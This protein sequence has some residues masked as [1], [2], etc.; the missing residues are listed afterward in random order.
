MEDNV[1]DVILA[2]IVTSDQ[3]NDNSNMLG[4]SVSSISTNSQ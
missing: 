1:A 4:L 3:N 2:S